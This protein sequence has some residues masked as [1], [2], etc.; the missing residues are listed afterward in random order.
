MTDTLGTAL[1]TALDGIVSLNYLEAETRS[2]PYAVY[3]REITE[4]RTKD[5]VYKIQSA[6]VINV[7]AKS[8]ADVK[9]LTAAIREAVEGLNHDIFIVKFTAANAD[10][11][12]DVWTN[13]IEYNIYQIS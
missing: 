8:F 4:H 3:D 2:Y 13:A 5:G 7:H 1:T 6:L 9:R 10:C 11:V 12:D